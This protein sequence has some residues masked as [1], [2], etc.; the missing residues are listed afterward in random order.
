[1]TN[2]STT[3]AAAA[4][5][6]PVPAGRSQLPFLVFGLLMV[7]VVVMA[8]VEYG[9]AQQLAADRPSMVSTKDLFKLEQVRGCTVSRQDGFLSY[10]CAGPAAAKPKTRL[11]TRDGVMGLVQPQSIAQ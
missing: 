6:A 7:A 8:S 2:P 5:T 10:V 11:W 9:R 4:Y 3:E 1:M